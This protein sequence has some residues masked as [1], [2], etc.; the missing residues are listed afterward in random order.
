MTHARPILFTVSALALAVWTLLLAGCDS[1]ILD[2]T[3]ND[4]TWQPEGINQQNIAAMVADPKDLASGHGQ[5]GSDTLP[6]TAAIRAYNGGA[7]TG[8]GTTGGAVSQSS[9]GGAA[10]SGSTG[11]GDITGSQ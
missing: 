7:D 3:R 8:T 5:A 1:E 4:R 2:P 6:A 9:A 11:I 10:G